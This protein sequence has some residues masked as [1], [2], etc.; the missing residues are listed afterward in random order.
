MTHR[1]TTETHNDHVLLLDGTE[2]VARRLTEHDVAAIVDLHRQ[3]TD[4]EQY[5]RFFT[6]HP[7]H[8]EE[9]AR[10][11]VQR[12]P[13]RC[14]LGTFE[15]G[16]LIGVGNYVVTGDAQTAEI[17]VAVAHEDHL[18][19]VATTL[20]RLLGSAARSH[21]IRWFVADVLAEN[22]DMLR[23]L[24]GTGWQ[25]TQR[26]DG[27]ELIVRIDLESTKDDSPTADCHLGVTK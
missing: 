4:R 22:K 20:L 10:K 21:G 25:R 5:F 26:Y 2:I 11:L 7:A 15:N 13:T 24:S 27:P 18:R 14:A 17:A 1:C 3:L 8:L 12:T 19:G 23:V 9:F 16:Q 6:T